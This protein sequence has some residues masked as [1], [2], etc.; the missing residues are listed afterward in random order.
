MKL[1]PLVSDCWELANKM[2]CGEPSD[3]DLQRGILLCETIERVIEE[4]QFDDLLHGVTVFL[5]REAVHRMKL[6]ITQSDA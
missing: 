6:K 2:D 4:D 5:G 1:T 3:M